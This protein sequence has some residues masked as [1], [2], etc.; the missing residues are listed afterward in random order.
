MTWTTQE[1]LLLLGM[2]LLIASPLALAYLFAR[3][4]RGRRRDGDRGD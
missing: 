3:L 1:S 4:R 2:A